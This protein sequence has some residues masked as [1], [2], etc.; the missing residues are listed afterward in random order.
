MQVHCN[1]TTTKKARLAMMGSALSCRA[2]AASAAVSVSTAHKWRGRGSFLD[3]SSRP[4]EPRLA[5]TQEAQAAA[6]ALRARGLT[7]DECL[8]ALRCAWSFSRSTLGRFFR[9]EGL[10]N[11]RAPRKKAGTFR[12]YEPGFLH[13]D[14]T[15]L[16]KIKG[17]P[18]FVFV[19]IDRATR[20]A[21]IQVCDK[22]NMKTAVRFFEAALRFF[23]FKIHRVL[24]D[25]GAEFTN[26]LFRRWPGASVKEHEF[27]RA[28]K[29]N[30]IRPRLT[31]P[32]T[33]QTNGLVERF[34]RLLKD[35]TLGKRSYAC[36]EKLERD[37]MAWADLYNLSRKHSSLGRITPAAKALQWYMLKPEIFTREP[38]LVSLQAFTT[39]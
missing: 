17:K 23:P 4:K 27:E 12:E 15:Y 29:A 37:L 9:R 33:P 10:G 7:L 31:R 18:R 2:L 32:Y 28:L 36:H 3:E 14:C 39:S 21:L 13:I 24:T 26:R 30:G 11:L 1:A 19:A 22:R 25:N 34:N 16:P 20:L 35:A 5:M 6:L 38:T 8:D